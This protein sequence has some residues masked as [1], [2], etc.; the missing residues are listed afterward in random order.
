M[1]IP[2]TPYAPHVINER[3][4]HSKG[5]AMGKARV[6][7]NLK[8]GMVV[9]EGERDEV[10]GVVAEVNKLPFIKEVQMVF[11]AP[12]SGGK[13]AGGGS[14]NGGGSKPGIK[15]FATRKTNPT[16]NPERVAV[17]GYYA[18]QIEGRASFSTKE[19]GQWFLQCGMTKPQNMTVVITDSM[20]RNNYV[21]KVSHGQWALTVDGENCVTRLMQLAE[22][23][24]APKP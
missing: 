20:R 1:D 15:E 2:L 17:L 14:D 24:A 7:V 6:T 11:G 5:E 13:D 12:G 18:Q 4:G 8:T 10:L 3:D 23:L 22:G 16:T 19:I 21:R 9:V